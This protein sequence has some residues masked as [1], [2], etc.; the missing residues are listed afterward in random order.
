MIEKR[1]CE[2]EALRLHNAIE[3][4]FHI[5]VYYFRIIIKF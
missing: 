5:L 3:T 2:S 4:G 1:I